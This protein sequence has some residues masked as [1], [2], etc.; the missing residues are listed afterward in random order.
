LLCGVKQK[1]WY[2][3]SSRLSCRIQYLSRI[4]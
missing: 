4:V 1:N 2:I 3:I